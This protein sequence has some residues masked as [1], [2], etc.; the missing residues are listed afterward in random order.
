MIYVKEELEL[1]HDSIS[2]TRGRSKD[3]ELNTAPIITR[4]AYVAAA[5][6]ECATQYGVLGSILSIQ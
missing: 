6:R 1:L 5:Y 3:H 4:D 2:D